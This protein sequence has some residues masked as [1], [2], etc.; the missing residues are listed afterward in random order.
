MRLRSASGPEAKRYL[1]VG[2][3]ADA[4]LNRGLASYFE[5][6]A[7]VEAV[8][9]TEPD[10]AKLKAAAKS[11]E[12]ARKHLL[13]SVTTGREMIAGIERVDPKNADFI[14]ARI[15]FTIETVEGLGGTIEELTKRM[16][17]GKYPAMASCLEAAS[18]ITELAQRFKDNARFHKSE[19]L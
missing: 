17:G 14:R 16:Q 6:M 10:A 13:D 1:Q 18:H 4:A 8:S 19:G 11:F 3:E 9:P 5:G 2:G 12:T 7:A 15:E